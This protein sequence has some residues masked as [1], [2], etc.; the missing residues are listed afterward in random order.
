MTNTSRLATAD[1]LEPWQ[2]ARRTPEQY[3]ADAPDTFEWWYFD[4]NLADGRALAVAFFIEPDAANGRFAYR[5]RLNLT[6]PDGPPLKGEQ[7]TDGDAAISTERPDVRIGAAWLQGD[8]DT[9]RV[10]VDP[11]NHQGLGLDATIQRTIPGRVAPTGTDIFL[12]DERGLGWV[13]AVPR[14]TLVGTLTV[15][16]QATGVQGIA[17]HDHNWGRQTQ[18]SMAHH[19]TWG[20]AAIGPY[21]AVFANV[22][23]THAYQLPGG[24]SAQSV[25]IASADGVLVNVYGAGAARVTAPTA[26]NP[27]P[28]NRQAYFARQVVYEVEQPGRWATIEVTPARFLH[29]IDLATETSSLSAEERARAAQM[30]TKPWY[31]EFV[32]APVRLTIDDAGDSGPRTHQGGGIVEFMDFHLNPL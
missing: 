31:T 3:T 32:A 25:Y 1:R 12:G 10:V 26:P 15:D 30:T 14:G 24:A 23:P 27:G 22:F 11:G 7:R 18:G 4:A 9:Y 29:D 21:T 17:Y 16:G 2:D 19:W 8:L 13:N 5:T 28:R 20:R 6:R